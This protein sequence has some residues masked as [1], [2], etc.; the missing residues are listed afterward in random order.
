MQQHPIILET[1]GLTKCFPAP[2]GRV[3][4]ACRDIS[5]TIHAGETVALVGE[6]GCG[7]STLARLLTHLEHPTAGEI[8]FEG[9]DITGLHGEALR[10]S[11]RAVQM[12]FQDPG[13][14]FDPRR[15]LQDALTEPLRNFERLARRD[16][17]QKAAELLEMVE[18]PAS[19]LT[20]YPHELSGGQ[21]QRAAIA[22]AL[23]LSPKLL[24]CDEAT[25][26][27][28]ASIQRSVAELLLR[29]QRETGVS[30]LFIC[31]DLALAH[32]M[33]HRVAVMYMGSVVEVVSGARMAAE[34][35]HPYTRALM[36]AV[37]TLDMDR[38]QPIATLDSEPPSP[39]SMPAGCPFGDRCQDC[40]ARCRAERPA[41]HVLQGG[42][43]AACH[44][45]A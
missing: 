2:G 38:T 33:A 20:R 14:S 44:K 28:D 15:R 13:A 12:V 45:L 39:L 31:H 34:A 26:A 11:R 3:L 36:D 7:K 10:Q 8:W 35:V 24:I 17:R 21:R 16:C 29:L 30:I 43:L 18:L 19:F 9:Q 25:S 4:T 32:Q 37:F 22:R 42:H 40:G 41:L 6:S 1:R 5:L 27:L 23:S